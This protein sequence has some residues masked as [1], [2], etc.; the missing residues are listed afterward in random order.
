ML[1]LLI[2]K[3]K[4]H[5]FVAL[6]LV[7]LLTALATGINIADVVETMVDG[8]GKTLGSVALLV[9]LGAMLGRLLEVSGGAQVLADTLIRKFGEKR[10]P[11]AL[12]VTALAF[13][14]PIF[15]DAGLVVLLPIVF[16]VARR[17]GG[18]VLL[19]ALP[20]AGAF[21]VMH[22]FV[23]PASRPGGRRGTA[24][25]RRRPEPDLRSAHRHP[26]L[27]P[28]RLSLRHVRGPADRPPGADDPRRRGH[29]LRPGRDTRRR[30]QGR[31]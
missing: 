4:L 30:R 23:P 3:A 21:A 19:Y 29:C 13:G 14:F 2:I 11:L 24:R 28:R 25:R 16:N 12:G 22:A 7:S 15:F 17:L 6:I 27:V 31:G 8:F 18:S 1:L 9:G 5:A 10:A 26:D 20:V